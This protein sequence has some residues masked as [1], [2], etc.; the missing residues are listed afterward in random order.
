MI[1]ASVYNSLIY[2]KPIPFD[3]LKQN[4]VYQVTAIAPEINLAVV[5]NERG[6]DL[7]VKIPESL[8]INLGKEERFVRIKDKIAK[9]SP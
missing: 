9:L 8:K 6:E 2:G 1:I 7:I 3:K 4:K 5:K